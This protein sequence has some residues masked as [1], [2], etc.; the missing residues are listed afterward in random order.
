MTP[1]ES[2]GQRGSPLGRSASSGLRKAFS[3]RPRVGNMVRVA[4]RTLNRRVVPVQSIFSLGNTDTNHNPNVGFER[5]V[6]AFSATPA[7]THRSDTGHIA[8]GPITATPV[9]AARRSAPSRP[10]DRS[11]TTLC[12]GT[13]TQTAFLSPY[14]PAPTS[15]NQTTGGQAESPRLM[16]TRSSRRWPVFHK[17]HRG[18]VAQTNAGESDDAVGKVPNGLLDGQVLQRGADQ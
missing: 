5:S 16:S 9:V 11:S 17:E 13:A 6:D 1:E 3:E 10:F 12:C 8:A 7:Y 2:P 15:A 18:V 14:R 4:P